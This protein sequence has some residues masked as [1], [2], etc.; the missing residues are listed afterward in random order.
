VVQRAR[1]EEGVTLVELLVVL[2]ILSIVLAPLVASFTTALAHEAR[3]VRLE[4]SYSNARTAM[5]RMRLDVRCAHSVVA[6]EEN[7]FGGFTLTLSE[8][9]E[10]ETG[11]C[12]NV[13]PSGVDTTG[14]QWCTI[15][16]SV[17]S[18]RYRLYRFLGVGATTCDG[19]SDST[20]QVDYLRQ[21]PGGWPDNTDPNIV[22]I[23]PSSWDGNIWPTPAPCPSGKLPTLTV[24]L[25]VALDPT[26]HPQERYE[27]RESLNLRNSSRCA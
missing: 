19:G 13:I 23:T 15:P 10:G 26:G 8:S 7:G 5:Q 14:V 9:H 1:R 20:F 17:D 6:V 27:L 4:N 12:P 11:W 22:S 16:D 3:A 18:T 25:N 2:G 24:D 21:P